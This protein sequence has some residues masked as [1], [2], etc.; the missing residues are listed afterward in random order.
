MSGAYLLFDVVV[1]CVLFRIAFSLSAQSTAVQLLFW[2]VYWAVQGCVMT[3]LWVVAH[4]CGHQA[5][6]ESKALNNAVGMFAHS[7]LLVPYHSWRISH[8]HHHGNT[9]SMENDEVFVPP[10]R[11]EV[12]ASP[13]TKV[14]VIIHMVIMELF[15]WPG[16]LVANITGPK[17][18]KGKN[19]SH[20]SPDSVLFAASEKDD[21]ARSVTAFF[22]VVALIVVA[23]MF[24]GVGFVFRAYVVPL[25][26][27]N[28][29]LVTITYL[30]HTDVYLPHYRGKDWN[31][32]RGALATVDRDYGILNVVFHHIG[33]TH[34]A[35]HLFKEI[36]HYHA[37]E[38][39]AAIKAKLGKYYLY[40]DT[41]ILKALWTN[42]N[43]C[44][45]VDDEGG[46]VFPKL[47][48][49]H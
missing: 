43:T 10:L 32:L 40:D 47:Q 41:P 44:Q 48:H 30:Q 5:F 22:S 19:N 15:G 26:I 28:F 49:S 33:D 20:F 29:W 16:Y 13:P 7:F 45:Y 12:P 24:L 11:S 3:G 35:H 25:L 34:V 31:W 38:A 2:P 8:A 27:T 9:G 42:L 14:A 4:E 1:I 39:T 21:V 37:Q 36:P 46:V 18:Y 17:K 23:A 6:S